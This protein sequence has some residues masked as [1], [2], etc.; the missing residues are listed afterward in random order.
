[1]SGIP[2][3]ART[4]KKNWPPV[5]PAADFR[6]R[7]WRSDDPN[8][9]IENAN[10]NFLP[11]ATSKS[12]HGRSGRNGFAGRLLGIAACGGKNKGPAAATGGEGDDPATP[13]NDAAVKAA[14]AASPGSTECGAEASTTMGAHLAAQREML[15]G[16]DP[17]AKTG[18][19]FMCRAQASDQWECEW[20]V[21][22]LPAQAAQELVGDTPAGARY[23]I[24]VPDGWREG[25]PLVMY[26]HG[27]DFAPTRETPVNG[28]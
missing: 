14:L 17:S 11:K 25:D 10:R 4:G 26:Q 3:T 28:P 7:S 13:F 21:Q 2:A 9:T 24:M 15:K 12:S 16:G 27:L 23:R 22:A 20:S 1:M 5:C 18:E 8:Y 6:R 19:S